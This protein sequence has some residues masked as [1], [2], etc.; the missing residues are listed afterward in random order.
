MLS[1]LADSLLTATCV[2]RGCRVPE[3][4]KPHADRFIP[5]R[6]RT[7]K[8]LGKKFNSLRDLW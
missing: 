5:T 1:I 7:E 2:K 4:P 8:R 3:H 6:N